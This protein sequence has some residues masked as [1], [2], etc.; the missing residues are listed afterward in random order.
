MARKREFDENMAL[1][2]AMQLFWVQGYEKTSMDELVTCMGV[3]R[4][5]I[6]DT[7]GNKHD[8]FIK[9]LEHYKTS[10][11]QQ[12]LD[13]IK[14]EKNALGKISALFDSVWSSNEKQ[15]KGC[16]IVN[17]GV[18]LSP[19]DKA[20]AEI[21]QSGFL[22]TEK[23]IYQIL[24]QGQLTGEFSSELDLGGMTQF[25]HNSLIGIRVQIKTVEDKEKLK[26]II[27]VTLSVLKN[28]QNGEKK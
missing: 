24:H 17:T 10:I 21:V 2:K 3:H 4:K 27:D 14:D 26:P 9:A 1:E 19:H 25:I 18:E 20:I 8:L 23:V 11:A 15:A 5:S 16:L 28:A 13:K 6:Y 22:D 7:F 12:L